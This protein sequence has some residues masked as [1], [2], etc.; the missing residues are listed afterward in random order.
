MPA[1]L[2]LKEP[3]FE[4]PVTNTSIPMEINKPGINPM[5]ISRYSADRCG[6]MLM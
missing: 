6:L 3:T 4:R 5:K 2:I 1:L